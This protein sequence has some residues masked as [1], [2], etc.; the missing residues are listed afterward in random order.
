MLKSIDFSNILG[1]TKTTLLPELEYFKLEEGNAYANQQVEI[2]QNRGKQ[3]LNTPI[4][5]LSY[6]D[7][8]HYFQTGSRSR[9][10]QYYFERRGRLL[11]FS[12]LA[13]LEPDD[14]Q[15]LDSLCDTIWQ[16]CSEPFWCVPAHFYDAQRKPLPLELYADHLDLFSCETAFA[17]AEVRSLL[18]ERLSSIIAEQIRIQIKRRIFTPWL[19]S[20]RKFFFEKYPNNWPS[21]CAS[22]IG[23]AALYLLD[24]GEEL[25][26]ILTRCMSCF[27]TYLSSFGSDGICLEGAGYFSYGFGMFTCFAQLL[28]A[29]T[30]G[31]L[32]LFHYSDKVGKIAGTQEWFYLS[33]KHVINFADSR[34]FVKCRMGISQYLNKKTSA[35]VPPVAEDILDDECYRYC[36][37]LRDII[38]TGHAA[39]PLNVDKT[40][41]F[42]DAQWFMSRKDAL[43]LAAKGGQNGQGHGHND[44]GSFIIFADGDACL[45]DL[46][47]GQ[48]NADYFSPKRY[49]FLTTSSR[50]HNVPVVNGCLQ[51]HGSECLAKEI[52]VDISS[53]IRVFRAEISACYPEAAEIISL[54]REISHNTRNQTITLQDT[55]SF[56]NA[57]ELVENFCARE[58]IMLYD[59]YALFS[60]NGSSI[61]LCFDRELYSAE[62]LKE[63]YYNIDD[64]LCTAW[65]LQLK[66]KTKQPVQRCEFIFEIDS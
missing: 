49:Q 35:Q 22:G 59:G 6:A 8:M 7:F 24:D 28:E 13:W 27:D 60:R 40:A 16:I 53:P 14:A 56:H 52:Q 65:F 47:A 18:G 58:E 32:D 15:W 29:R 1:Q 33:G 19:N 44:C 42:E 31:A 54:H 21:V 51:V 45:C 43:A 25:R 57:G 37:A 5:A 17:L 62:V 3:Y 61:K 4:P 41:W 63:E 30:D 9:Y 34:D 50:G 39:L 2:L 55:A 23:G 66:T 26:S 46:G 11:V 36:I 64:Q 20:E 12:L 48:Y 38:W 10:D